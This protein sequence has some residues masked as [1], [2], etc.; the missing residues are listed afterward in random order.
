M[1]ETDYPTVEDAYLEGKELMRR[2]G[3][4]LGTLAPGGPEDRRFRSFFGAGV[5]VVIAAWKGMAE[6]GLLPP[7]ALFVHY[8]WALVFMCLYP[9]NEAELCLICGN[10][11]PKTVRKYIWPYINSLYELNYYVVSHCCKYF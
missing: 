9:T 5:A 4:E 1:A 10:R 7:E 2:G 6:H 11:D 8:L 3:K